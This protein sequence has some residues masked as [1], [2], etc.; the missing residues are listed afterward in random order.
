ML[1]AEPHPSRTRRGP[2]RGFT[3]VELMTVV[4]ILGVLAAIGIT[5]VRGHM[6]AAK[7][8]SALAGTKWIM[9]AET[10]FRSERGQYYDCSGTTA[11]YYPVETPGKQ[12]YAWGQPD[13]ADYARWLALG[14][15]SDGGTQ[16]GYLVNAGL[17]GAATVYPTLQTAT[18]PSLPAPTDPWYVIQFM[19]NVDGDGVFMKGIITSLN[20]EVYVEHEGE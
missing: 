10:A 13:H 5:L 3:L 17:P 6:S 15:P 1:C 8:T 9:A 19:G 2:R 11:K 16:F 18:R 7:T 20:A 14:L 4:A 12:T